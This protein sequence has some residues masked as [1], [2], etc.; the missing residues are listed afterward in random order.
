MIT[1]CYIIGALN[2]RNYR[3]EFQRANIQFVEERGILDSQFMVTA[4]LVQ[5]VKIQRV[6]KKHQRE[7]EF[8]VG[9]YHIRNKNSEWFDQYTARLP[10]LS[11]TKK[12]GWFNTRYDI[13]AHPETHL[14]ISKTVFFFHK[15]R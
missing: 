6:M 14:L 3:R 9:T 11:V 15:L 10:E 13:Y 8:T 12:R 2:R 5:H 1:R 7:C 4:P